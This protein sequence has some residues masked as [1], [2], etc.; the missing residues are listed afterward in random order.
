MGG[1]QFMHPRLAALTD[2]SI[3]YIGRKEAASPATGFP[4]IYKREQMAILNQ[5]IRSRQPDESGPIS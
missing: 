1:W 5:A 3:T 4:E 2:T